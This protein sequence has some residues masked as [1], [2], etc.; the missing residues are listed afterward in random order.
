M[1]GLHKVLLA[2]LLGSV[3]F[4]GAYADAICQAK[5]EPAK[6]A[7]I[8]DAG[9]VVVGFNVQGQPCETGCKGEIA[10]R[11]RYLNT[12]GEPQTYQES[13][14]WSSED[15]ELDTIKAKAYRDSCNNNRFGPCRLQKIEVVKA[16][17]TTESATPVRNE[18]LAD[19]KAPA[20]RS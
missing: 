2:S 17:C 7:V 12:E 19:A 16:S 15:G 1:R 11:V 10:F 8:S 5:V 3:P 4:V 9:N 14:S 18:V 6:D 13:L 20:S